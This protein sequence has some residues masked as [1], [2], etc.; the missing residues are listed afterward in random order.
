MVEKIPSSESAQRF[1]GRG[2]V[3]RSEV[4]SSMDGTKGQGVYST[5]RA[6]PLNRSPLTCL[7]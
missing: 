7:P 2:D 1:N 3:S 4:L 5:S 6:R